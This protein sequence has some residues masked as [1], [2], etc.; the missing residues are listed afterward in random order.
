MTEKLDSFGDTFG[1]DPRNV[2]TVTTVVV[3][4][5]SEIPTV[6]TVGDR[7]TGGANVV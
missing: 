7:V 6:D 1:V 2:D 5:R 4:G 3:S